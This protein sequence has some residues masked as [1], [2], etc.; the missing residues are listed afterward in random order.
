[1]MGAPSNYLSKSKLNVIWTRLV[2]NWEIQ[3]SLSQY[4]GPDYNL[5]GQDGQQSSNLWPNYLLNLIF[6][7]IHMCHVS[8]PK[9]LVIQY[10]SIRS[11]QSTKGI[12]PHAYWLDFL[13]SYFIIEHKSSKVKHPV[14]FCNK[15]NCIW[16]WCFFPINY[17][18]RFAGDIFFNFMFLQPWIWIYD[19]M[20]R[21]IHWAADKIY[22]FN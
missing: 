13:T 21:I 22:F 20:K 17:L 3:R 12:I 1:M 19:H 15:Q 2:K 4:I 16:S 9:A 8:V 11:T 6:T 10:I 14:R 7:A 18:F 5:I